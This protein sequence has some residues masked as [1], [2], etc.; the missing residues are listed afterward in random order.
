M[1]ILFG[2]VIWVALCMAIASVARNRFD[3]DYTTWL[4]VSVVLSPLLGILLLVITG[5]KGKK[6]PECDET[7]KLNAKV[8][9]HCGHKLEDERQRRLALI[10]KV[11]AE[12][13]TSSQ[14]GT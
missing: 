4:L 3:R 8:C 6:C 5:S 9:K 14:K 1:G 13:D 11:L 7:V 12:S 2:I 10:D